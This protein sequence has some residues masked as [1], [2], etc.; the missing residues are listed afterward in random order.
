[1]IKFKYL[2]NFSL[3]CQKVLRKKEKNEKTYRLPDDIIVYGS[4]IAL[5][6]YGVFRNL[7]PARAAAKTAKINDT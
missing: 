7:A 1:M 3:N 4:G 5:D 6:L 2:R